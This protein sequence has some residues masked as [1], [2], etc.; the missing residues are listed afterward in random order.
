MNNCDCCFQPICCLRG[1]RGP[2]GDPGTSTTGL[3]AYGGLYNSSVQLLFFTAPDTPIQVRLNTPL[4]LKNV[5]AGANALTV[6]TS[7]VYEVN[8]NLLLNT[9]RAVDVAAAV[10]RNGVV[11]P[12]TRGS[13]TLAIDDTTTISYDG[14]LSASTIV[15]LNAGDVIDLSL[16]VLRTIPANLDAILNSYA[17]ATLTLKKIDA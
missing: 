14:R 16:E 5:T 13:Q 7:G 2:K 10:R 6:S 17:N 11:I 12:E 4:P 3:S 1:P 8:Y 9:S 15:A